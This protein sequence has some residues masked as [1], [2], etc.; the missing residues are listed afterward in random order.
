MASYTF[1]APV[2]MAMLDTMVLP[3]LSARVATAP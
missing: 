3:A 2:K 1:D